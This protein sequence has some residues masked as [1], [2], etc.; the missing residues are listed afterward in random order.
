MFVSRRRVCLET[1]G[2]PELTL[3]GLLVRLRLYYFVPNDCFF[4]LNSLF[5][6]GRGSFLVLPAAGRAG[7]RRG[8]YGASLG[9]ARAPWH[10]L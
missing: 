7:G 10:M 2:K 6:F 4:R 8:Q 5:W 3:S 1:R 9:S